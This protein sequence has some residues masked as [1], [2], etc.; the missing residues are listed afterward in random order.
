MKYLVLQVSRRDENPGVWRC[1]T[2]L[3]SEI[4]RIFFEKLRKVEL[5]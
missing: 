1:L 5:K 2:T 3:V 4:K